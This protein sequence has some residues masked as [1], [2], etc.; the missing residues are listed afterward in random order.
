MPKSKP[1]TSCHL[2]AIVSEFGDDIFS[3]DSKILFCKVCETKV[4]AERKFTVQQH[5]G[6]EKHIR[7]MQLTSKKKST[8]LLLQE[9]ASMKDN[10][11][12]DFH[13]N[14]CEALVS[15]NIQFSTLNNAKL[16]SFLE[17]HFGRPI[18]D[19]STLW[20][21]YLSQCYD[22]TISKHEKIFISI[23]ET[24]DVEH[25]YM[26]NIVIGTLEID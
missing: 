12:S 13:K 10:K 26:A 14:F 24:T 25:C 9:T 8:Q 20:K 22:D 16:K 15:A 6:Y 23:D 11:L 2:K 3:I 19:K 1:Y 4:A 21:N 5:V 17:L 7:A 18:P